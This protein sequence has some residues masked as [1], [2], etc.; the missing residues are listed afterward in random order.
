[1]PYDRDSFLA[2]LAVGRTLWRPHRDLG[3]VPEP[4]G[5]DV[6]EH[7]TGMIQRWEYSG[8]PDVDTWFDKGS[9][10]AY[11]RWFTNSS[12]PSGY[13]IQSDQS[14]NIVGMFDAPVPARFSRLLIDVSV[15]GG[16]SGWNVSSLALCDQYGLIGVYNDREFASVVRRSHF[17]L[18][19]NPDWLPPSNVEYLSNQS[20]VDIDITSPNGTNLSRQTVVVDI[21]EIDEPLYVGLHKCDCSVTFYSIRAL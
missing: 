13:Y 16:P 11:W 5:W 17:T 20:Y 21:S 8:H 15:S 2:G 14:A 1:M 4:W 9:T 3:E 10:S 18:Y 6:I 7:S 12:F 19:H